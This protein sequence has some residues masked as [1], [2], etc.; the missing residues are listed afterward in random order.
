M[1]LTIF[2][3]HFL[4]LLSLQCRWSNP[5]LY[6]C[7]PSCLLFWGGAHIQKH[8]GINPVPSWPVQGKCPSLLHCSGPNLASFSFPKPYQYGHKGYIHAVPWEYCHR[9]LSRREGPGSEA[10]ALDWYLQCDA[11]LVLRGQSLHRVYAQAWLNK[12]VIPRGEAD[13]EIAGIGTSEPGLG[14]LR[15]LT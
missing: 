11:P 5:E 1:C 13:G 8:S 7:K 14:N 12:P 3:G 9:A 4:V 6:T 15:P 10:A 2:I